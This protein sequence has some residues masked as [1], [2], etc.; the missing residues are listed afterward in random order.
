MIRRDGK[1]H[2]QSLGFRTEDE[3]AQAGY[4]TYY[5]VSKRK[6]TELELAELRT[7]KQKA[8]KDCSAKLKEMSEVQANRI[9][10][11]DAEIAG[12]ERQLRNAQNGRQSLVKERDA[13]H[14]ETTRAKKLLRRF[15]YGTG[16]AVTA[17]TFWFLIR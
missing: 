10:E 17:G 12:L 14:T 5:A 4:G 15:Y 8:D 13:A 16:I 11:K 1:F 3:A 2:A 9:L 6:A 7:F